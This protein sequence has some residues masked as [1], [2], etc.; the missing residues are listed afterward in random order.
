MDSIVIRA[1][2]RGAFAGV[3]RRP[4]TSYLL[5]FVRLAEGL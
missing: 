5:M 1:R 3:E 4:E 2:D